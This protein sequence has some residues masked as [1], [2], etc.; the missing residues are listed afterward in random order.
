MGTVACTH[1][2]IHPAENIPE[3]Y[4][5]PRFEQSSSSQSA[6]TSALPDCSALH[7]DNCQYALDFDA[8]QEMSTLGGDDSCQLYEYTFQLDGVERTE[9]TADFD[10]GDESLQVTD[11]MLTPAALD[12]Q[13]QFHLKAFK[14]SH[15]VGED[16]A[17][18]SVIFFPRLN[19]E[20]SELALRS[21]LATAKEEGIQTGTISIAANLLQQLQE[22][23]DSE[24][25]NERQP[26]GLSHH[27]MDA[28][29]GRERKLEVDAGAN[30]QEDADSDYLYYPTLPGQRGHVDHVNPPKEDELFAETTGRLEKEGV[31]QDCMPCKGQQ[32]AATPLRDLLGEEVP[33]RSNFLSGY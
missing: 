28:P 21:I 27:A 4:V 7:P 25:S 23:R 1:A 29:C 16:S 24:K 6:V 15:G 33:S 12:H 3:E 17:K 31:L 8:D 32:A 14:A 9:G 13:L 19:P 11:A 22:K 2:D 30:K 18:S 5:R 10:E 20:V 26:R